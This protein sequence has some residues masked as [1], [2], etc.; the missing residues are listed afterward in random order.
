MFACILQEVR[1]LEEEQNHVRTSAC[2]RCW[3]RTESSAF[4]LCNQRI[5]SRELNVIMFPERALGFL[6]TYSDIHG[7]NTELKKSTDKM[8]LHRL[9]ATIYPKVELALSPL[10]SGRFFSWAPESTRALAQVDPERR[11]YFSRTSFKAGG[12]FGIHITHE[13]SQIN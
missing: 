3:T 11:G 8:N 7:R 13:N 10:C 6:Q 4:N 9:I 5:F 1:A 2:K 12:A